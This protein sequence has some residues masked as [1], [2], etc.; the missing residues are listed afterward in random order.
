MNREELH[1]RLVKNTLSNYV[2][3]VVAMVVGL[4]TFRLLYQ[5]FDK[6]EFGFWSLL[7]SVFGYGVLLDFG[8]GFAAQKRV[9][10]LSVQG[11]WETLSKVLSTIIFLYLGVAALLTLSVL[12]SAPWLVDAFGVPQQRAAEFRTVM[13]LFFCGIGMAFPMGV[14]PEILRGQQRLQLVNWLITGA[15]IIRLGLTLLALH[16]QWS[17]V[18]IMSI[19]LGMSLLPDFFAAFFALRSMPQ[20]RI[21]W[22]HCSW[23]SMRETAAFSV[24]A[25]LGTTTNLILSKTDQL[26]ITSGLGV[27]AVVLYQAGAKVAEV[28]RDFTRQVQDALS[29]AAA[30]LHA[31]GRGEDL[32][33]LLVGGTRWSII[34]ATPLYLLCASYLE[35]L[36]KLLTG[37]THLAFETWLTGQVLLFWYYTTII[38]HSVSKRIFMMTGHEK[39]LMWLGVGEAVLNLAVSCTL[40]WKFRSVVA[41]AIGSLIPTLLFGWGFLWPWM[42]REAGVGYL[43]LLGR[44]LVPSL[45][46]CT[47]ALLLVFVFRWQ[48]WFDHSHVLVRL[49]VEGT[50]VALS[51]I[52]GTWFSAITRAE[53]NI[54]ICRLQ[55]RPTAVPTL[56]V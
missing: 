46:G 14:Y 22:R 34:L 37:D 16:Y 24:Y 31:S 50:L 33:E 43:A 28:F 7:W 4:V 39:K 23:Q 11:N 30:H 48:G 44:T 40:V 13:I 2:R 32:Q 56:P 15:L 18:V 8:F 29:P 42:A 38:T 3:T 51:A 9:A 54:L 25:Y 36:L 45:V 5:H 19:A 12:I 1:R 41:V 17:F 53:R 35:D 6:E 47:G 52:A 21:S 49:G 20:V 27:G 55:R 26:V 10:E